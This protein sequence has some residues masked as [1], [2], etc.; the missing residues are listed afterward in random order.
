MFCSK[1]DSLKSSVHKYYCQN[2]GK[3][4]AAAAKRCPSCGRIFT[5]VLCPRCGFSGPEEIFVE[6]CPLCGSSVMTS[7]AQNAK[8][9][10]GSAY[11][12]LS[13]TA[14]GAIIFIFVISCIL[15]LLRLL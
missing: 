7:Q 10:K 12:P 4:V 11:K 9:E 3:E 14:F 8:H 15:L 1:G 13:Y 5:S 2:C 6:G